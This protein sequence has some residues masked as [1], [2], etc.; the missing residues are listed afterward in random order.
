MCGFWVC[1]HR[2]QAHSDTSFRHPLREACVNLV[3]AGISYTPNSTSGEFRNVPLCQLQRDT[4][5]IQI[6]HMVNTAVALSL[7]G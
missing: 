4:L 1:L 7:E 3:S 2:D 6:I 5:M